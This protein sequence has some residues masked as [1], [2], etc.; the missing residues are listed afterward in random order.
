LTPDHQPILDAISEA[1]GLWVAAGF[2]GHG[3]MIAPAVGR[4][5]A[6]A[7][8]GNRDPQLDHFSL[9]RFAKSGITPETLVV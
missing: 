1:E 4:L 7:V 6:N 3:F 2:S 9:E 5:V 8:C